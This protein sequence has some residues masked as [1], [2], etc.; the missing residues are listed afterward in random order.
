MYSNKKIAQKLFIE[1]RKEQKNV[2]RK[3]RKLVSFVS[4]VGRFTKKKEQLAQEIIL[5]K[6]VVLL[7]IA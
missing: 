6:S 7:H 1:L 2:G 5:V 3:L 4:F